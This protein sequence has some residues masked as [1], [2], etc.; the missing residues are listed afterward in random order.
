[1]SR[2]LVNVRGQQFSASS[3]EELK[4]L[5][6]K[7]ELAGGDI[8]QPPGASDWLYA[9]EVPELKGALRADMEDFGSA[10]GGGK[11]LPA[12]VKYGFA[13]VLAIGSVVAWMYAYDL[14]Q[15]VPT[16]EDLELIG[17]KGLAFT[18]VLVT[19][20]G[21]KLHADAS[22]SS[23]A[24]GDLPKN[25][26]ADL[27]AKRGEWYKLRANG[28]EGYAP[29]DAVIPA[30]FFAD[31][32]TKK[33]YDPLYNPDRYVKVKNSAWSTVPGEGAEQT[34][35]MFM[36]GNDSKFPMTDIK[37]LVKI[38][39]QTGTVLETKEIAVEGEVPPEFAVM[40][41]HLKADPRDKTS[42]DRIMTSKQF[43]EVSKTDPKA[44]ERYVDEVPVTLATKNVTAAEIEILEVRAV[45]PDQ[46]PK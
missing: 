27:L 4:Q 21:A 41:G 32:E 2:W 23:P 30:Y 18:E 5:A 26:K 28:A 11:E 10:D 33:G 34:V 8:V 31:E 35:F 40:I 20:E 17:E 12:V 14:S 45:P 13:G 9:V 37:M 15:T 39:D 24:V 22:K 19:A 46:M 42:V 36:I 43:E 1:M 38:K 16:P 25:G 44:A 3:M 7:G 6:K 29:I